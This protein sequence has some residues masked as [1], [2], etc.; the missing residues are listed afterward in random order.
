M[1]VV[2]SGMHQILWRQDKQVYLRKNKSFVCQLLAF[3]NRTGRKR[4]GTGDS[5][6]ERFGTIPRSGCLYR[7]LASLYF[8]SFARVKFCTNSF[9]VIF[10][11]VYALNHK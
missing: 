7:V 11:T 10:V 8:L 4:T 9:E 5:I 1:Q 2:K 6:Q 3:Y